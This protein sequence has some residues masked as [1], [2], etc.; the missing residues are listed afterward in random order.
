MANIRWDRYSHQ[1]KVIDRREEQSRVGSVRSLP[2][3]GNGK[4][5]KPLAG[6]GGFADEIV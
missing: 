3:S 1:F 5:G 6:A 2:P 4:Q